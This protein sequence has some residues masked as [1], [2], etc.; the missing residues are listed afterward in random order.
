MSES[1]L[2][3]KWVDD[4][5]MV[6]DVE[7]VEDH[8]DLKTFEL[9]HNVYG[10]LAFA[11]TSTPESKRVYCWHAT[12]LVVFAIGFQLLF[13]WWMIPAIAQD[14]YSPKT[15]LP[16]GNET[17]TWNVFKDW[18][19]EE[20]TQF[21]HGRSWAEWACDGQ[22]FDW[23][24]GKIDDLAKY[25]KKIKVWRE[26]TRSG[27]AF[28]FVAICLWS[29]MIIK[30]FREW[31]GF[32]MLLLPHLERDDTETRAVSRAPLLKPWAQVFLAVV[33]L[34]RLFVLTTLAYYGMKFLS[35]TD[36]LKDFILNSVAL[37][38]VLD[39]KDLLF[40]ALAANSQKESLA[41][42]TQRYTLKA[43]VP[44]I[45]WHSSGVVS[46]LMAMLITML[47]F[48]ELLKPF[49]DTMHDRVYQMLCP[50]TA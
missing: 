26:Y 46:V 36:N 42:F 37:S 33:S 34:G 17:W 25:N 43:K 27:P 45:V 35:F 39:I 50:E 10:G 15:Q 20:G 23:Q 13:T 24:E 19:T 30:A 40:S 32:A 38:F 16:N 14:E 31:C 21:S 2:T 5:E 44:Q 1:L 9:E 29:A 3:N 6:R 7:T 41:K 12:L 8:P 48:V 28:G 22:S 11:L 4:V 47:G 49:S 18:H